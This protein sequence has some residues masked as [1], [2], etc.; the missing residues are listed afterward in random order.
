MKNITFVRLSE[1]RARDLVKAL[2]FSGVKAQMSRYE[3]DYTYTNYYKVIF[4]VTED[5]ISEHQE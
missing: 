4:E 3:S 5:Q 2:I 1:K